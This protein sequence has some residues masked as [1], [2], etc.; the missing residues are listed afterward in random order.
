EGFFLRGVDD[1]D[2]TVRRCRLLFNR[3][4]VVNEISILTARGAPSPRA[5]AR[6]SPS[7]ALLSGGSLGSQALALS[8]VS[9][10]EKARDFVQRTLCRRQTDSLYPG[11]VGL[12]ARRK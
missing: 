9:S 1:G 6:R 3:E 2:P 7:A 4:F 5:L 11:S 10:S 8:V 12:Q